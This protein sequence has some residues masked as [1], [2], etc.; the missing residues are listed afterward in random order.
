MALGG[1]AFTFLH[2]RIFPEHQR[3]QTR[4]TFASIDAKIKASK[5]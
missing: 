2:S 5:I 1:F 3:R 4:A